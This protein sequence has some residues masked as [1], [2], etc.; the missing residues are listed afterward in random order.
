MIANRPVRYLA[1]NSMDGARVEF[2]DLRRFYLD[3][4]WMQDIIDQFEVDIKMLENMTP[5]SA[6]QYIRKRIGYDTFLKEYAKE[7][8]VPWNTLLEVM[9]ELEERCKPYRTF[10]DWMC[11]I[12]TYTADLE[13]QEKAR[14]NRQSADPEKVQLMTMHSSKGL[15]FTTVFLIHANEGEVPYQKAVTPEQMEEERRMFYVAMTRAK[16]HLTI[17]YIT[18]KNGNPVKASRFVEEL[19]GRH[20]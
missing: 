2:E 5:Y 13:E 12:D 19:L 6:I 4:E 15:E 10:Q 7:H 20:V 9:T 14:R 11:H 18:E 1:R 8:Q 3:K 17:S 16:E